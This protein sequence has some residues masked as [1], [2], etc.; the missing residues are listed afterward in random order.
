MTKPKST[1]AAYTILP[2]TEVLE[3]RIKPGLKDNL[4]IEEIAPAP[5]EYRRSVKC[6]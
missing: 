4:P 2:R 1:T 3:E 5:C 6:C